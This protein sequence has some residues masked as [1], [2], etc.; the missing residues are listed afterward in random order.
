MYTNYELKNLSTNHSDVHRCTSCRFQLVVNVRQRF[1]TFGKNNT[2][3]KIIIAVS[4]G[5][6][7]TM[8]MR[9]MMLIGR[10]G[11]CVSIYNP[12]IIFFL[13]HVR[14]HP[15]VA[16]DGDARTNIFHWGNCANSEIGRLH[17]LCWH[18]LFP[19]RTFIDSSIAI[20]VW[21]SS[22]SSSKFI[23]DKSP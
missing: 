22:S 16:D 3:L 12:E 11:R 23:S 19:I 2:S 9:A 21:I 7:T 15:R 1:T 6:S 18:Y 20:H 8:R 4:E 5:H 17:A 14:L 13:W 10:H